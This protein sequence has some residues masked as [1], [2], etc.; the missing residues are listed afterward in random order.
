MRSNLLPLNLFVIASF[1]LQAKAYLADRNPAVG[2][3]ASLWPIYYV[4]VGIVGFTATPKPSTTATPT[5]TKTT[6]TNGIITPSPT[7]SGMASNCDSFYKVIQD[8]GCETIAAKNGITPNQFYAWNLFIGTDYKNLWPNYYVCVSMIGIN[9][10]FTTSVK[11]TTTKPGNGIATPTPIQDDMTKS[12]KKFYKVVTNDGCWSI[13]NANNIDLNNFYAWNPAV[14]TDCSGLF[15]GY[16]VCI[17][18]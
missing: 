13:A 12:C 7:Q 16:Y 6:P 8:D 17:G 2:Q 3:C 4:C 11:P 5:S 18:V 10:S 15:P 1:G 9:P 14:K